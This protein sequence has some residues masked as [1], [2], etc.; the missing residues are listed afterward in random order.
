[1][2]VKG[3]GYQEKVEARRRENEEL[4]NLGEDFYGAMF[5]GDY[6]RA[7]RIF[8]SGSVNFRK[9]INGNFLLILRRGLE[10][11]RPALEATA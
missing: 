3:F 4:V 9:T 2:T 6:P 10:S 1:M 11:Q 8:V 5:R 7:A